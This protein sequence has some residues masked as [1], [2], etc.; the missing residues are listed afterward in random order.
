LAHLLAISKSRVTVVGPGENI[1]FSATRRLVVRAV[2][3]F[4]A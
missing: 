1:N 4:T 3:A 2:K